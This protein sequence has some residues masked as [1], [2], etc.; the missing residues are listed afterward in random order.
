M[1]KL[2]LAALACLFIVSAAQ[3]Q[4]PATKRATAQQGRMKACN[5][6]A[7]GKKGEARKAF[8]KQC[9]SAKKAGAAS[10]AARKK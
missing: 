10:T 6:Q 1:Q 5:A 9:L 8:M 2:I 7:K 3:A 4:A